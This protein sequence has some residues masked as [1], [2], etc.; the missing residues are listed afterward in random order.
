MMWVCER[1]EPSE[2]RQAKLVRSLTAG[3]SD[4]IIPFQNRF[5]FVLC[6][7]LESVD[8]PFG[9]WWLHPKTTVINQVHDHLLLLEIIFFFTGSQRAGSDES[10]SCSVGA[11]S[12]TIVSSCSSLHF[13]Q[14]FS[15][16]LATM[17]E[18]KVGAS[19]V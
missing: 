5:Y 7:F 10:L 9:F 8:Q 13:S 3:F 6:Q 1:S 19:V 15:I 18:K 14:P 17:T 4:I 2:A 16:S 12:S 11:C